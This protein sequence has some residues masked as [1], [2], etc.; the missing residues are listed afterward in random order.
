MILKV[1]RGFFRIAVSFSFFV[2]KFCSF[3][4][5]QLDSGHFQ[6]QTQEY[7]RWKGLRDS[8]AADLRNSVSEIPR[9]YIFKVIFNKQ[10]QLYLIFLLTILK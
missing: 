4:S 8:L 1:L 3:I 6:E 10:I 9:K 5:V 7:A 2:L